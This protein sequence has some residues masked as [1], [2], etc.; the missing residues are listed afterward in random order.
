MK[1][2]IFLLWALA[3]FAFTVSSCK[4]DGNEPEPR[5]NPLVGTWYE[6]NSTDSIG[7]KVIFT[8]T[9]VTAFGY[10]TS[11]PNTI[12]YDNPY[13]FVSDDEIKM[14]G[15]ANINSSF[16]ENDEHTTKFAFNNDTLIIKHFKPTLLAV[17][18]LMPIR[19]I[20][21]E[22]INKMIKN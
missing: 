9:H 13:I 16:F 1:T 3:L 15:I 6:V 10:R 5:I 11:Y 18:H 19:L 8:D 4:N 21:K 20:K 12:V 22:E 7:V 17:P 2:K 14:Y